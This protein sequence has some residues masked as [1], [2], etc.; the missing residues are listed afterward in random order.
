MIICTFKIQRLSMTLV[1]SEIFGLNR[2]FNKNIAGIPEQ[3]TVCSVIVLGVKILMG[4]FN[5]FLFFNPS[6]GRKMVRG[7]TF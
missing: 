4:P 7:G 2:F 3:F 6:I 1:Y 5:S